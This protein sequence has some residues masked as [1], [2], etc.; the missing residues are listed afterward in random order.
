MGEQLRLLQQELQATRTE[1]DRLR[2]TRL[3]APYRR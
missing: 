1:L 3:P 2:A